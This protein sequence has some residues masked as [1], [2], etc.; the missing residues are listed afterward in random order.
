MS[1]YRINEAN[2]WDSL[3]IE[4]NNKLW[5]EFLEAWPVE[6]VRSMTLSEYTDTKRDNAFIYWIEFRLAPLGSIK[7]G[8]AFKFGVFARGDAIDKEATR[9]L[10]YTDDYG[11]LTKYG[12]TPEEAFETV[13]ASILKIISASQRGALEEIDSVKISEMFKWKL[14]F[15]YQN[16]AA[17]NI[18]PVFNATALRALTKSSGRGQGQT[19]D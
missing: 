8:S 10:D 6:R 15:Q 11:W 3:D 9:G 18:V 4:K 19:L 13:K 1:E 5:G 2:A 7:G 17:P 12:S 14:A 16:R